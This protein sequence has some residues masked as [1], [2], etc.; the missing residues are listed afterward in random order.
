MQQWELDSHALKE[1]KPRGEAATWTVGWL[2]KFQNSY[3]KGRENLGCHETWI[4][5][6]VLEVRQTLPGM[7]IWILGIE[8]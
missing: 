1:V 4:L 5:K 2:L 7:P 8:S 3:T 6:M